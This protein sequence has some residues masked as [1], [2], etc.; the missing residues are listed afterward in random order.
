MINLNLLRVS[1]V[2]KILDV[3]RSKAYDLIYKGVIPS[4][5][6]DGMLRVP[7]K[8]LERIIREGCTGKGGEINK[9]TLP[10]DG[11]E[12]RRDSDVQ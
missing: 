6:L 3:S 8:E 1:T 12:R 9:D 4:I 2:A 5:E 11:S 7:E 10:V